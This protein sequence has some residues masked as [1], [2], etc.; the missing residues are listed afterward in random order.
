M[1]N[2]FEESPKLKNFLQD[3]QLLSPDLQIDQDK[4]FFEVPNIQLKRQSSMFYD[5]QKSLFFT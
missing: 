4:G 3:E 1:D 2:L 5:T